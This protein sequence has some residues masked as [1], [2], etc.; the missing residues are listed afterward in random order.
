MPH[1]ENNYEEWK[2]VRSRIDSIANAIFLLA[3][4]A[5]TLSISVLLDGKAKG[6]ITSHQANMAAIAW[7]WL[8]AAVLIFLFLKGKLILQSYM[9]QFH[10]QF[11]DK[12]LF[13]FNCAGWLIGIAGFIAF[14][15]GVVQLVNVAVH[16]VSN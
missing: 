4:G 6:L 5:L 15:V 7:Y 11:V 10:T 14:A 8:L 2:E 1:L 9:L 13:K 16:I 12:H 3:G